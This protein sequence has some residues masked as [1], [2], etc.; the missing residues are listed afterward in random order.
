MGLIKHSVPTEIDNVHE[1][2]SDS[3]T[4]PHVNSQRQQTQMDCTQAVDQMFLA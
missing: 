4:L 2:S 3:A 1:G